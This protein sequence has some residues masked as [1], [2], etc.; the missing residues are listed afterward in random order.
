MSQSAMQ[1]FRA[2]FWRPS[3]F[4]HSKVVICGRQV[5]TRAADLILEIAFTILGKVV[6]DVHLF[7]R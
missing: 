2:F 7:V 6:V 5:L 4:N 3:I 1:I